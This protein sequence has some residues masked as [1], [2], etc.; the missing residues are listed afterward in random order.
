MSTTAHPIQFVN[1]KSPLIRV[2]KCDVVH[3]GGH[4]YSMKLS[5]NGHILATASTCGSVRLWETTNYQLIYELRVPPSLSKVS[6]KPVNDE[7]A[8]PVEKHVID[9]FYFAE[10]A[11]NDKIV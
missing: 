4:I 2:E 5:H 10:F 3:P 7:N 8:E 6:V 1:V 11:P 9:E